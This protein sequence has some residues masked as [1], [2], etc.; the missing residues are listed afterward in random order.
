VTTLWLPQQGGQDRDDN[1][2]D[3]CRTDD[4]EDDK[5]KEEPS[6]CNDDEEYEKGEG[7]GEDSD[8][9]DD[10]VPEDMPGLIPRSRS[11]RAVRQP[12]W[13]PRGLDSANA[14]INQEEDAKTKQWLQDISAAALDADNYDTTLYDAKRH[15]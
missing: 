10:D 15:Y 2:S 5:K 14:A 7:P 12:V 1:D 9:E 4:E 3:G 6:S 8:E 13:F 11:G